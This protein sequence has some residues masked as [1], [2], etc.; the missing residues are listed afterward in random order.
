MK[1]TVIAMLLLL[2]VTL[3]LEAAVEDGQVL[4]LGGTVTGLKEGTVG[5]LDT[6]AATALVFEHAGGRVTVP[7]ERIQSWEY[8][9]KLAHNFGVVPT[10]AI[11]LL[12]HLQRRHFFRISYRDENNVPQA[13]VFE[14]PKQM[15]QTLTAVLQT[16]VPKPCNP[17]PGNARCY[18]RP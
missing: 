16:R 18:V 7:Y 9:R 6:T 17:L 1:K 15:P 12:K 11:A 13:A 2:A 5:R 14:V 3:P 4:Y 8:S 10:V